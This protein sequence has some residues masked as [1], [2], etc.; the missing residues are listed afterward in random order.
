M[1]SPVRRW[2]QC[3]RKRTPAPLAFGT[4]VDTQW[5]TLVLPT[6]KLSTQYGYNNVLRKRVLP[7]WRVWRLR[8]V[9]RM[10][11]QQWV[12]ETFR[13]RQGWQTVRNSWVLLSGILETAVEYGYLTTNPAQ[14]VKFPP[15]ELKDAPA[16]IAG[17]DFL[18]LLAHLFEP[19][20]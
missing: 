15:K 2:D 14:G 16:I 9:G 12:A 7:Y 20:W 1:C 11:V 4:F 8:D 6:L 18:R 5:K 13:Q 19:C 17:A 3:G 10:D